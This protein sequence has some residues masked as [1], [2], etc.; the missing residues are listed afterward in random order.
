MHTHVPGLRYV[1]DHD[2]EWKRYRRGKGF[3][4][5]TESG[6]P[7]P[8]EGI[9][10]AKKLGIPPAWT[11]V[12]ISHIENG[13]IQAVGFDAKGRKQYLYHPGWIQRSQQNKFDRLV[14]F[15][16][17]L[18]TLRETMAAHMRQHNLSHERVLATIVWLLE[19]TFVRVGNR[20]YARDNNSFGL[21]TLREKHV[22][23]DGNSIQFS[24]PGKSGVFHE[25]DVTHKRVVKTI[26]QCLDL[27]GY[28]LFQYL[29]E[30]GQRQKIDSREVNEYL[31]SITGEELTAKDFRTWG[32]TTLAGD[33][34]YRVGGPENI[35]A[36]KQ[37][38]VQAAKEVSHQLRNTVA[39]CR[40]YYIHPTIV[41]SYEKNTLVP[42]FAK[43]Y[44]APLK[45]LSGLSVEE[46]AA[47][48]LLKE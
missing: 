34:L 15:G 8:A 23:V 13:H 40:K 18:P 27:P 16:E 1:S 47:W 14:R 29:D 32:G 6:K 28:E 2:F 42:H 43:V 12:R 25:V 31:K 7:V 44:D 24:F 35:T 10:R 11:E 5:I 48:T 45:N 19:N 21:T 17:V 9:E 41:T 36:A 3:Q 46:Q 33:F 22:T 26:Q 38:I 37:A 39:V 20:E 4:Y 30:S